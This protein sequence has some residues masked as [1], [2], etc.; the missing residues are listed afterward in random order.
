MQT[1]DYVTLLDQ[2]VGYFVHGMQALH[3]WH[4][5]LHDRSGHVPLAYLALWQDLVTLGL[6]PGALHE[7][8][9]RNCV[10]KSLHVACKFPTTQEFHLVCT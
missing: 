2:G 10:S 8:Y 1:L 3:V 7:L 5:L 4:Q 9:A 6:R